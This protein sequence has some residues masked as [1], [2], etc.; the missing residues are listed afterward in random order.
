MTFPLPNG[1]CREVCRPAREP[2]YSKVDAVVR[3]AVAAVRRGTAAPCVIA[4]A[5]AQAIGCVPDPCG[6]EREE[7][8]RQ[9]DKTAEAAQ[10]VI[11]AAAELGIKVNIDRGTYVPS[12]ETDPTWWDNFVNAIS[13]LWRWAEIIYNVYQLLL[14]IWDFLDQFAILLQDIVTLEQCLSRGNI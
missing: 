7:L 2:R 6:A 12:P 4:E 5:V 8:V 14:A 9:A 3:L 1:Y 11:D 10:A 13:L